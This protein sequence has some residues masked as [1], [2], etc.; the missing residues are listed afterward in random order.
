[1]Y[2]VKTSGQE[3]EYVYVVRARHSQCESTEGMWH[4]HTHHGSSCDIDE[5]QQAN[6]AKFYEGTTSDPTARYFGDGHSANHFDVQ[7]NDEGEKRGEDGVRCRKGRGE[8][9][10]V[11]YLGREGSRHGEERLGTRRARM[12]ASSATPHPFMQADILTRAERKNQMRP[13]TSVHRPQNVC[14]AGNTSSR[15]SA[16]VCRETA[17]R[18]LMDANSSLEPFC[19]FTLTHEP[20]F[21][22][23][24]NIQVVYVYVY[25]YLYIYIYIHIYIY[26]YLCIHIHTYIYAY[27]HIY[28]CIY[29]YTCRYICVY[30]YK[31]REGEKERDMHE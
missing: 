27:I 7:P 6:M 2:V 18:G 15:A 25:T 16:G 14:V 23:S 17:I 24:Y 8:E 30:T 28:I 11:D 1:M 13:R 12:R 31:E 3:F 26:I 10:R 19:M 5:S 9:A 21:T 29:I 20:T 22:Q 4:I